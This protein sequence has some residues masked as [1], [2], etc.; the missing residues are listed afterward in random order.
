MNRRSIVLGNVPANEIVALAQANGVKSAL[1]QLFIFPYGLRKNGEIGVHAEK[2]AVF[3][4]VGSIGARGN[5]HDIPI[6]I[7]PLLNQSDQVLHAVVEA[8]VAHAVRQNDR[9]TI[10]T[11]V[12]V[13]VVAV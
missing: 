12:V 2:V 1:H 10:V 13:I 3:G 7:K 8:A 9:E 11:V 6:I 4:V 5:A